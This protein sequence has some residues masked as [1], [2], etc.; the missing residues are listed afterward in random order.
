VE[1]AVDIARK[2]QA[3]MWELRATMSRARLWQQQGKRRKAHKML[4]RS[5]TGSPKGLTRKTCKGLRR[6]LKNCVIGPLG[7]W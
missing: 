1:Q 6:W 2:P 4:P 7:P 5:T 3:E